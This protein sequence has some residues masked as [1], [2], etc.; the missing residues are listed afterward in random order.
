MCALTTFIFLYTNECQSNYESQFV[1]KYADDSLIV[2]LL[3]SNEHDH[4][5][6]LNEF[7]DWCD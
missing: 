3:H 4:G 2:S 5:S 7:V 6:V 1:L